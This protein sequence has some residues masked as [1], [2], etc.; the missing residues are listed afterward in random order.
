MSL[1]YVLCNLLLAT[2]NLS[3]QI[4]TGV[5][6]Q[7]IYVR[8]FLPIWKSIDFVLYVLVWLCQNVVFVEIMCNK[9]ACTDVAKVSFRPHTATIRHI[10]DNYRHFMVQHLRDHH[11][12]L[13][14]TRCTPLERKRG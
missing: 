1:A 5:Q 14:H 9:A 4:Y 7:N 2:E 6:D 8:K 12:G 11:S 13:N 10:D 3:L